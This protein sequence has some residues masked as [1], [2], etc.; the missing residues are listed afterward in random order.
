MT[1]TSR[2]SRLN[3]TW[4]MSEDSTEEDGDKL[5]SHLCMAVVS[6]CNKHDELPVVLCLTAHQSGHSEAGE[7]VRDHLLAH[8][9]LI[10]STPAAR[11]TT[12]YDACLLVP[13]L[14][15]SSVSASN[16]CDL[17]VPGG[18][19]LFLAT[20]VS[21][22]VFQPS[23]WLSA[24]V[25]QSGVMAMMSVAARVN[26]FAGAGTVDLKSEQDLMCHCVVTRSVCE[27]QSG[28][29]SI[30]SH[31]A[32]VKA[33]R[34]YWVC[35]IPSYFPAT[36]ICAGGQAAVNDLKQVQ[37]HKGRQ[38]RPP[39]AD[40][41]DDKFT[42]LR[43][44]Q[45]NRFASQ[46]GEDGLLLNKPES[47]L[48]H[49]PSIVAVLEEACLAP[50]LTADRAAMLEAKTQTMLRRSVTLLESQPLGAVVSLP[51]SIGGPEQQQDQVLHVD[52]EHLCE[53]THLPPHYLAMF[54]PA[55]HMTASELAGSHTVGQTAFVA[56]S[57]RSQV[58]RQIAVLGVDEAHRGRWAIT[59]GQQ[60][61]IIRPHCKAGDVILFDARILHFGIANH[62][63]VERPLL[64]VNFARPWF[65][66]Y[67]SGAEVIVRHR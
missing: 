51:G 8:A 20:A 43:G 17:L 59:G 3:K 32:A 37:A 24:P 52:T 35:V 34:D 63:N 6:L 28:S 29:L 25:D 67:Q 46:A 5:V 49:D 11:H 21:P 22:E 42:I 1:A 55:L 9:T 33:I 45:L 12:S 15:L 56:G 14:Q 50:E 2:P 26:T 30:Q 44:E 58:A 53:H 48:R 16:V 57:H 18:V 61:G 41:D 38:W 13:P 31:H 54:L 10:F 27:M 7:T 36:L 60:Y 66:G 65:S 4:A 47:K 39:D 40:L 23:T 64:F 19:F 62:S